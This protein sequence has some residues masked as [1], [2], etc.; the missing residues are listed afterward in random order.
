MTTASSSSSNLPAAHGMGLVRNRTGG[1]RFS[2]SPGGPSLACVCGGT[3]EVSWL[4]GTSSMA[5]VGRSY[6]WKRSV[7][8]SFLGK[9][10]F[11]I[12]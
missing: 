12:K 5:S 7:G 2:A 9:Q 4:R 8:C 11:T 1:F 6:D 3:A 10:A